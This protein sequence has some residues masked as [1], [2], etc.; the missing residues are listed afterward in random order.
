MEEPLLEEPPE[1][2]VVAPN[3]MARIGY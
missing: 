2:P 1:E 3:E